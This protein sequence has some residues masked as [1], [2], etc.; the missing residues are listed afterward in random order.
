MLHYV[1]MFT[2]Q[3]DRIAAF[4][5]RLKE[6]AN[7]SDQ[8]FA[9]YLLYGDN[10]L[11]EPSLR[12]G[13]SGFN[14]KGTRYFGT[15]FEDWVWPEWLTGMPSPSKGGVFFWGLA[16]EVVDR[17]Q[18]GQV[19]DLHPPNEDAIIEQRGDVFSIEM[20]DW[21]VLLWSASVGNL[22]AAEDIDS[23]PKRV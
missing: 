1:P 4:G 18:S 17:L 3:G 20:P 10:S 21:S 9:H 5:R 13:R 7:S 16:L 22:E 23:S 6:I 2:V 11:R 15:F 14:W 19:A 8:E 12:R